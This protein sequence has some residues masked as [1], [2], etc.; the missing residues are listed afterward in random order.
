MEEFLAKV[1]EVN[2]VIYNFVW[3]TI[4]IVL[5]LGSGV[6]C[7]IVTKGF[8]FAHFKHWVNETIGSIFTD[9]N[10][11]DKS[12][13]R[14]ISQFQALCT[15]LSATVGTGNIAGVA[16]AIALGGPGAV[17]WMCIPFDWALKFVIGVQILPNP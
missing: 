9:K 3:V 5:L 17:F 7:T 6:L 8:Q 14:N 1:A 16:G 15:A 2:G 11:T 13:K 10:V 12:D 4:G